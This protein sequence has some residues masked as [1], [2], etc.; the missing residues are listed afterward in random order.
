MK[1]R[2]G[3][4]AIALSVLAGCTTA[5]LEA[6]SAGLSQGMAEAAYTSSYNNTSAPYGPSAYGYS[7]PYWSPNTFS[8]YG[9]WPSSYSYGDWVG[10]GQCRNTGSFYTCDTNGDGYADMYGNTDD[11]SY[12]S[13]SLRVNG[14]GEAFTWGSDCGCWE[15]NRAYDGPRQP[16]EVVIYDGD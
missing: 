11:G 8:S 12:A 7:G 9:G 2:A 16:D 6:I 1:L 13:S 10:Y 4:G 5:E 14:R 3:T 15:R